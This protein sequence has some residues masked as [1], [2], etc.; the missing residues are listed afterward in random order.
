MVD[1]VRSDERE[2]LQAVYPHLAELLMQLPRLEAPQVYSGP[3]AEAVTR[4][5]I[6]Q[7]LSGSASATIY[8]RVRTAR[9][10][11]GLAGSWQLSQA[12]LLAAG[13]S[14]RKVKT[15][16]AF[17][18]RYD[19]ITD[20]IEAWRYLSYQELRREVEACWGLSRWSSDMLAI[21]YF[22]HQDV[23]PETDGTIMRALGMLRSRFPG[24]EVDPEL[25]RPY[26]T[27]LALAF[28]SLVDTGLLSDRS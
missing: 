6:G 25:V 9:D 12:D 8:E 13:L 20:E 28:W 24:H 16:R 27:F 17:G 1:E 18:E 26:R 22:G 15:V 4:I 2:R 3:V 21:F 7:M 11:A 10:R 23:F 5:V 14:A 19:D